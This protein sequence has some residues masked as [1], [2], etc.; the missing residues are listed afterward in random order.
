MIDRSR[1]WMIRLGAI[2]SFLLLIGALL[3]LP[4][5]LEV[6]WWALPGLVIIAAVVALPI[7]WAVRKVLAS[8]RAHNWASTFALT[9]IVSFA[10]L[11]ILLTA[12]IYYLALNA[13]LR[14]VTVPLATLSNGQ[15][16][17]VF[18]GMMHIGTESFYKGVVYDLERALNDGY[19]L[20]YEG[21]APDPEGDAWFRQTLADGG[22]LSDNYL[23]FGKACGLQFQLEY[24][25]LLDADK[26]LHPGRHVIAD[27]T[28]GDLKR[29]YDRLVRTDPSFAAYARSVGERDDQTTSATI[30]NLIGTLDRA[31]PG[32]RALIGTA[33]RGMVNT[34]SSKDA[35]AEPIN[36]VILDY[37][38]RALATRII[39][40]PANRIY[41]TY[42]AAHLP[43]LL[44]DLQSADP[45][46]Q[47]KSIKWE[48]TIAAPD[49]LS[50]RLEGLR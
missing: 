12:P 39:Q 11:A 21:V 49:N 6:G 46:W 18:Q 24:F 16:T 31:T 44:R 35:P 25:T 17:V 9:I 38:N 22:D 30:A 27:V 28:T 32:Q 5:V 20:F 36:R 47:L 23:A 4:V 26:A 48:R 13:A 33:C 50:G 1:V 15:K 19:V 10:S 42:G 2:L 8:Q 37:R 3:S 43:G 45:A 34:I 40:S 41:V 7:S 14:P 29:E